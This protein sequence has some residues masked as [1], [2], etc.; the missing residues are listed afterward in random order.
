[1]A[2]A[3]LVSLTYFRLVEARVVREICPNGESD[4]HRTRH[5]LTT[6]AA[7]EDCVNRLVGVTGGASDPVDWLV[8]C[9][10]FQCT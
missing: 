7:I 6:G 9:A 5:S 3:V 4:A 8:A 10:D 2:S 1:M